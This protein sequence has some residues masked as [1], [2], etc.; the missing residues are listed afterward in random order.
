MIE[1]LVYHWATDQLP[2][3]IAGGLIKK[4]RERTKSKWIRKG[5]IIG[6]LELLRSHRAFNRTLPYVDI[7][8]YMFAY[9]HTCNYISSLV[10][11][12]GGQGGRGVAIIAGCSRI[13]KFF[14]L[15]FSLMKLIFI[16]LPSLLI[17]FISI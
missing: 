2:N 16:S 6:P 9:T 4:M 10:H 1:C 15:R 5:S 13:H 12:Q 17:P 14:K 11:S 3:R 7:Y 8:I